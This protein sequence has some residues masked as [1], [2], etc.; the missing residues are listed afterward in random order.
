MGSKRCPF[1]Y[2]PN[3]AAPPV[4]AP[5]VP[6]NKLSAKKIIIAPAIHLI[7]ASPF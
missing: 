6:Y 7:M 1:L 2:P 3:K 4:T 5:I